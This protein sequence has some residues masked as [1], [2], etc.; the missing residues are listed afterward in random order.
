MYKLYLYEETLL[1]V[2]RS[3]IW[4][5]LDE[6]SAK[7]SVKDIIQISQFVELAFNLQK[8]YAKTFLYDHTPSHISDTRGPK[9]KRKIYLLPGFILK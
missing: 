4:H 1:R 2:S 6:I 9:P 3:L 8:K 7:Q 5:I